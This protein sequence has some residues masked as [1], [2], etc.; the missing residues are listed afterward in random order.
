MNNPAQPGDLPDCLALFRESAKTLHYEMSRI[1]ADGTPVWVSVTESPL[2]DLSGALVG[3]SSTAR[4]ITDRRQAEQHRDILMGELNHRVKNSLAVVQAIASQTLR[5]DISLPDARLA[6]SERLRVMARAHDL[7]VTSNWSGTDLASVIEATIDPHRG[8]KS[9]FGISGPYVGLRP[10]LAVTFSL[11][12]HELCTNA[13]KYGALSVPEGRVDI[14]W[15]VTGLADKAR[16]WWQWAETGGPA[17]KAPVRKGFGSSLIEQVLPMELLGEVKVT[18]D[19]T[20]VV[21]LFQSPVP[22]LDP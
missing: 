11:V 15:T 3:A 19:A 5:G 1:K 7:L 8:G 12:L 9:R 4:D 13:A 22:G 20:G 2:L 16:L 17:V 10:Q 18:Y 21:C 6:F 14:T